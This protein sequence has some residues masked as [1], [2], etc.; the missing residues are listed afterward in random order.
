MS[1]LESLTPKGSDKSILKHCTTPSLSEATGKA[2]DAITAEKTCRNI[3][4]FNTDPSSRHF[5]APHQHVSTN[6][7]TTA[8]LW[9]LQA[10]DTS[11]ILA[12]FTAKR[13]IDFLLG[14]E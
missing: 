2:T 4:Y 5:T 6:M 1:I 13:T 8:S 9:I 3:V 14:N 11:R 12:F 7:C 10:A